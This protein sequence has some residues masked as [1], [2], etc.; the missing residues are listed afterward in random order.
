MSISRTLL[1]RMFRLLLCSSLLL[2]SLTAVSAAE[3]SEGDIETQ[4]RVAENQRRLAEEQAQIA[5]QQRHLLEKKLRE[6]Q[7]RMAEQQAAAEERFRALEAECREKLQ[8]AERQNGEKK[9]TELAS[10]LQAKHAKLLEKG[11][12]L[13]KK[14][15]KLPPHSA[16]ANE[17]REHLEQIGAAMQELSAETKQLQGMQPQESRFEPRFEVLHHLHGRLAELVKRGRGE[18]AEEIV[19]QLREVAERIARAIDEPDG[20]E[21]PHA[22]AKEQ[23]QVVRHLQEAA[24]HLHAAG[25]QE[26]AESI[27]RRI[28]EETRRRPER[29]RDVHREHTHLQ[30]QIDDLRRAV[31][32]MRRALDERERGR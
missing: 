23:E 18:Q 13:K 11:V 1:P 7:A 21:H 3:E 10:H 12:E 2:P 24:E 16:E 14:L 19:R 6:V 26:L 29:E 31:H 9:R 25:H 5:E 17:I 20:R 27:Q 15:A 32:E 8:H 22:E 4:R 30:E 28:H